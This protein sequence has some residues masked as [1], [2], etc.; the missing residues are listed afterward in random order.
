MEMGR[1]EEEIKAIHWAALLHDLGKIGVPDGILLKAGALTE[2]E[3]VIMKKHPE[4][5]ARIV[6]PVKK[7][8][9]VSPIIRAHQERYDG[10]GYPDG[11]KGEQIPFGARLLAIADAYGAMTDDRIYR[12]TRKAP[13]ALE[14]LVRFKGTQFDP[15]LVDRFITILKKLSASNE[16]MN[17]RLNTPASSQRL[18]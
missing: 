8:A 3:W 18:D 1:S 12:K 6:A 17:Q 14:E 11:L 5:G 13:D 16:T 7:L 15:A 4:I 10:T 2:E 9:N